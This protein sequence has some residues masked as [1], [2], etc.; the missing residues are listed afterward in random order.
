MNIIPF[1]RLEDV[2][3]DAS[4]SQTDIGRIP[5]RAVRGPCGSLHAV[6]DADGNTLFAASP[7]IAARCVAAVNLVE[8]TKMIEWD[9]RK[10]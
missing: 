2:S 1:A 5:W 3:R 8:T 7:L 9:K 6:L 10:P 4:L